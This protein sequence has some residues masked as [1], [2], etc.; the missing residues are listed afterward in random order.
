M[1]TPRGID[2]LAAEATGR[3]GEPDLQYV[4]EPGVVDLT[5][6]HPD[7]TLLDPGVLAA[8]AGSVLAD[9]GWKAMT[10]GYAAGPASFREALTDHLPAL[11]ERRPSPAELLVTSGNSAGLELV[12]ARFSQ[13][14]DAILVESPTYFLAL[15][16]IGDHP[17]V[18]IGVPTDDDGII[19]EALAERAPRLAANNGPRLVYTVPTHNNPTGSCS[20]EARRLAVLDVAAGHGLTIIEDDVYR[21]VSWGVHPGAG[22]PRSMWTLADGAGVIRLGSFSKTIGPGLRVGFLTAPAGI[23]ARLV[24]SGVLD[25]GGGVN[26]FTASVVGRMLADGSYV[27]VRDRA[28][29]GYAERSGAL[30]RGLSYGFGALRFDEP[31]GGYFV[32]AGLPEPIGATEFVAAARRAGVACSNGA[33]FFA[34]ATD[35]QFVRISFSL[36]EPDQLETAGRTLAQVAD[37]I[38]SGQ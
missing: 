34:A 21:E 16:I 38:R 33:S 17:L 25:S 36:Y 18:V 22:L 7:P 31:A 19:P 4:H 23:V 26:H 13:P 27:A 5:W 29:A 30:V 6:G 37:L 12:L 14:G 10:Y 9:S 20:S 32:W 11:G 3:R 8:A 1:S 15:R 28:V 2:L 35:G 24:G